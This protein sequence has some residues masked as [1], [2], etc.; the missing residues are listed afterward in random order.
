MAR[1]REA[2]L[3]GCVQTRET[4]L[5]VACE[6]AHMAHEAEALRLV[7]AGEAGEARELLLSILRPPWAPGFGTTGEVEMS[8]LSRARL[9]H[10]LGIA[11]QQVLEVNHALRSYEA[12]VTESAALLD[13]CE[14]SDELRELHRRALV[15]LANLHQV[16]PC[17]G[18]LVCS[19]PHRQPYA[20]PN[21]NE[22]RSFPDAGRAG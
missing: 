3:G 12:V 11:S 10:T 1:R 17:R 8:P 7:E 20:V 14:R 5:C 15:S 2:G 18:V 19:Q 13:I 6:N 21:A 16:R 4:A 22:Q 9:F